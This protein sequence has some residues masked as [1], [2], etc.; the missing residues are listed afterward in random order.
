MLLYDAVMTALTLCAGSFTQPLTTLGFYQ[1]QSQFPESDNLVCKDWLF[2][3]LSGIP[4]IFEPSFC[5][6]YLHNL[7][8]LLTP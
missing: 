3:G 4:S 6:R 7:I 8:S 5:H 2:F 1:A